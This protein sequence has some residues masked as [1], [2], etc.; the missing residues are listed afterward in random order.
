MAGVPPSDRQPQIHSA[1]PA[2]TGES[3]RTDRIGAPS[4][5]SIRPRECGKD[6]RG[7][8]FTG[9]PHFGQLGQQHNTFRLGAT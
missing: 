9:A 3:G 8:S 4:T 6:L 1:R 7:E 2:R 5:N